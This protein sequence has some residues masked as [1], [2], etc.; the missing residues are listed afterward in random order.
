[1]KVLDDWVPDWPIYAFIGWIVLSAVIWS[2]APDAIR[3]LLG[4]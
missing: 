3:Y 1:M 4:G 2:V